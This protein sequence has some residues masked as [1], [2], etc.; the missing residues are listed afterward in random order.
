MRGPYHRRR[1]QSWEE[2]SW[3][4]CHLVQGCACQAS[5][6]NPPA[7]TCAVGEVVSGQCAR[8]FSGTEMEVPH[9]KKE[10]EEGETE[11]LAQWRWGVRRGL[12]VEGSLEGRGAE[13]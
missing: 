7:R 5:H 11:A 2:G 1:E 6:V 10:E 4:I 13:V 9:V 8:G 12:S 3:L